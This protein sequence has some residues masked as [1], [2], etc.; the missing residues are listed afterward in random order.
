MTKINGSRNLIRALV[1]TCAALSLPVACTSRS[2]K[3]SEKPKLPAAEYRGNVNE[4]TGSIPSDPQ[5]YDDLLTKVESDRVKLAS[6]YQQA[7]SEAERVWIVAQ[8]RETVIR[9]IYTKIFSNWYGTGWDFNGT[10]EVPRQGKIA[11]GYFVST[12]LRDAGWRVQR[13]RLAQQASEN[14]IM[15]LTGEP[16]IKRFRHVAIGDFVKTVKEWGA[17]IYVVGLDIHTGFIVNDGDEVYFVHSSYV[18]PFAVVKEMA[19]D[20]KILQSSEYRVLGKITA[21]EG[22]IAKWLLKKEIVTRKPA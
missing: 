10:T 19:L 20:S 13:A 7:T 22:L 1:C 4:P 3:S 14:I 12:V 18:E 2:P 21:D 6:R 16:Y 5:H 17:G 8:A 9:S 15:S 11:C